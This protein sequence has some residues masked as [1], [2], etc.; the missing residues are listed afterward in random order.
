MY[1]EALYQVKVVDQNMCENSKGN[2]Q[3]ELTIRPI[4]LYVET[5]NDET[6]AREKRLKEEDFAVDRIIFMVMTDA[7][8]GD[9][10][11]PGWVAQ[12]LAWL[13]LEGGEVSRL[14]KDHKKHFSL[15][16]KVFDARCSYETWNGKEREKW[17]I[18]HGES[19]TKNKALDKAGL[20]SLDARFGKAVKGAAES[21]TD[22]QKKAAATSSRAEKDIPF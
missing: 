22:D 11:N 17:Q 4:G 13:G 15:I 5:T 21:M 9:N 18:Q 2:P 16:R 7:T 19:G 10:D 8:M 12:T 14:D 1:D 6:G 20:K 3:L